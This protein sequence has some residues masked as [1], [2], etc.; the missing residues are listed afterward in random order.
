MEFS[1][2]CEK[3][4]SVDAEGFAVIDARKSTS[5]QQAL[6]NQQ[7]R[8]MYKSLADSQNYLYDLIDKMGNASAKA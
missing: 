1:F 7:N 5:S 3:L 2:N 4:L 6:A 8:T